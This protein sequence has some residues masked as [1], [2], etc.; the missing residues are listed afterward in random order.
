MSTGGLCPSAKLKPTKA[1][2]N[3]KR[4]ASGK[5]DVP[6]G[7]GPKIELEMEVEIPRD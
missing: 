3:Q 6:E 1:G 2:A 4:S 7:S 5:G